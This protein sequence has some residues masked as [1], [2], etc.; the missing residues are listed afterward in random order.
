MRRPTQTIEFSIYDDVASSPWHVAHYSISNIASFTLNWSTKKTG[1]QRV[2]IVDETWCH[3][4]HGNE[5]LPSLFAFYMMQKKDEGA[6]HTSHDTVIV[7]CCIL[8]LNLRQRLA[9]QLDDGE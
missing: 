6:E 2:E 8:K 4:Y 3:D 7:V 1:T 9:L 5:V